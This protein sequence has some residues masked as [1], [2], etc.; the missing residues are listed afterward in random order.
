MPHEVF[1]FF[2]SDLNLYEGLSI[3]VSL[4]K[5]SRASPHLQPIIG[6]MLLISLFPRG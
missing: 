2:S 6:R 3:R 4:N 5:K 1:M